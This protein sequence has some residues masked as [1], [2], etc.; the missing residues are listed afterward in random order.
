MEGLSVLCITEGREEFMPFMMQ[1]YYNMVKPCPCE[2]VVVAS[3]EDL[4]SARAIIDLAEAHGD[5]WVLATSEEYVKSTTRMSS[6]VRI[7]MTLPPVQSGHCTLGR[8]R[9]LSIEAASFDYV[10]FMDDDDLQ[11]ESRLLECLHVR[12]WTAKNKGFGA[13][14]H[15]HT[16]MRGS[17]PLMNLRTGRYRGQ[18][19]RSHN[20]YEGIYH[21]ES[22]RLFYELNI[23]EDYHFA[24]Q[25]FKPAARVVEIGPPPSLLSVNLKHYK[26]VS[27]AREYSED[28]KYWP[29]VAPK[30]WVEGGN[31]WTGVQL[32]KDN[33]PEGYLQGLI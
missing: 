26:N 4:S 22:L 18:G 27:Q 12:E 9:N 11:H 19:R 30:E 5:G 21:R 1:Q 32:L 16:I 3:T 29:Y 13:K 24:Q 31:G 33:A 25:F 23:G 6:P 10:T 7:L 2:L 28:P 17:S 14:D 20:W 15:Y 8:K